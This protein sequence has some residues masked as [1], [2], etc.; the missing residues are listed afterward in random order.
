MGQ[1]HTFR[2]AKGEPRETPEVGSVKSMKEDP[3]PLAASPAFVYT[4]KATSGL[5]YMQ[6][7]EPIHIATKTHKMAAQTT[8]ET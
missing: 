7:Q 6:N 2:T 8:I 5:L 1:V 4:F 3:E